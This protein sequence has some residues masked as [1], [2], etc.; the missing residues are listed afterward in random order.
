M[1]ETFLCLKLVSVMSTLRSQTFLHSTRD[2]HVMFFSCNTTEF[3]WRKKSSSE[4][5]GK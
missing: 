5:F 3:S 1:T 2:F 4:M